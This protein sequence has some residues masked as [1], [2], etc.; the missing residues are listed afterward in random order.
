MCVECD[1]VES[2]QKLK[3]VYINYD[4]KSTYILL[5]KCASSYISHN[6]HRQGY[7][8]QDISIEQYYSK[9]PDYTTWT[10]TRDPIQRFI[11]AFCEL[12][13][14]RMHSCLWETVDREKFTPSIYL[15]L[16]ESR[17]E[18]DPHA[19]SQTYFIEPFE[20]NRKIDYIGNLE[21]MGECSKD[22]ENL[23]GVVLGKASD[24]QRRVTPECRKPILTNSEKERVQTL[25]ARDLK[26]F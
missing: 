12:K 2:V 1:W 26:R 6:I 22:L 13:H 15:D 18:F 5:P 8:I 7:R 4:T 25:Y 23:N 14:E 3:K 17:G 11:A 16:L 21:N 10:F 20:A 19:I 24:K 9:F